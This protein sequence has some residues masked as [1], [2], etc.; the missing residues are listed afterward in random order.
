[1]Q[2][3]RA[4]VA[5]GEISPC[6]SVPADR[7]KKRGR[8]GAR[9][10]FMQFRHDPS[11]KERILLEAGGDAAKPDGRLLSKAA[12]RLWKELPAD[13]QQQYNAQAR[14][15]GAAAEAGGFRL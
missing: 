4:E 3:C 7:T 14:A 5:R 9:T 10:G 12:G 1:M 11:Q 15:V 13:M 8:V 6:S 2:G